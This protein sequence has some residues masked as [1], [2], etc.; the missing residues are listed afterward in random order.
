MPNW[1]E[2]KAA[3]EAAALETMEKLTAACG[4]LRAALDEDENVQPSTVA[5]LDL[6]RRFAWCQV[7]DALGYAR[8]RLGWDLESQDLPFVHSK[9]TQQLYA[10]YHDRGVALSA[11]KPVTAARNKMIRAARAAEVALEALGVSYEEHLSSPKINPGVTGPL[12]RMREL[13]EALAGPLPRKAGPSRPRRRSM[14][15]RL[16]S[17]M[18]AGR[19]V[20]S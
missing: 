19:P 13:H 15:Q 2:R 18:R 16:L 10:E 3:A 5:Q 14:S 20:R 12:D 17:R 8:A 4:E 1:H 11:G 6:Q 7:N 9:N